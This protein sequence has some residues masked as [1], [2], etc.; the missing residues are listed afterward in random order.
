MEE[1]LHALGG[2][3]LRAIPTFLLVI[4]LHFFLKYSFFKPLERILKARFE[5]TEGARQRAEEMVARAEAK[6]AEYEAAMRAARA[7]VYQEQER[8][9]QTLEDERKGEVQAAHGRAEETIRQA[10]QQL[11]ADVEKA[12]KDLDQQSS[13]LARQI[14]EVVLNRSVA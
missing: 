2:I 12:K 1:T 4:L 6:T 11:T 5:A 9:H 8:L 13:I 10:K 3:L 14:A 7:E